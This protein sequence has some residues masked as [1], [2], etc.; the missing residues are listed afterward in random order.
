M[1]SA[2]ALASTVIQASERDR[3]L[4]HEH[5]ERQ[6]LRHDVRNPEHQRRLEQPGSA[7]REVFERKVTHQQPGGDSD[8]ACEQP[9]GEPPEH[10]HLEHVV[11]VWCRRR[12]SRK[13]APR[14]L[15]DLL[16]SAL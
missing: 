13:P 2:L 3:R 1:N 9:D 5:F 8:E 16:R 11:R 12:P 7:D 15:P 10:A 4:A 6:E 14:R